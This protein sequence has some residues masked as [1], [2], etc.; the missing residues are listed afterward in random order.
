MRDSQPNPL[1]LLATVGG[2]SNDV[3]AEEA[4]MLKAAYHI[5]LHNFLG[6]GLRHSCIV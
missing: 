4:K 2:F 5:F 1:N 6:A 3:G